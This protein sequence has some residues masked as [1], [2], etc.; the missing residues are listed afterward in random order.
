MSLSAD[1]TI[2]VGLG[3][4]QPDGDFT[5]GN[6]QIFSAQSV[7]EGANPSLSFSVP[8]NFY[9]DCGT[10]PVYARFRSA[11]AVRVFALPQILRE[12]QPGVKSKI[13]PGT[14]PHYR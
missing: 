2:P 7:S 14:F 13:T 10:N 9:T 5:D 11:P 8:A 4:F 6:E 1:K 12:R 3:R